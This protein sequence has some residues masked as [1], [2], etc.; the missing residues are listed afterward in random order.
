MAQQ[1]KPSA[2]PELRLL[3]P[4]AEYDSMGAEQSRGTKKGRF[5]RRS[6]RTRE[7][8]LVLWWRQKRFGWD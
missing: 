4:R 1:D 2:L 7:K 6:E 8:S 3:I 5:T